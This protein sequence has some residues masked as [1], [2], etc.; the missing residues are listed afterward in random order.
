MDFTLSAYKEYIDLILKGELTVYCFKNFFKQKPKPNQFV[1]IRHD[2]D[3]KPYRALKMAQLEN[4][5]GINST[6]YFRSKPHTLN[7]EII[8]KIFSL[9]HE[10]G[11]HYE[12]LSDTNGNMNLALI[13]FKNNLDKLRKF[14][15]IS[16]ISMHGRPFSQYDNRDIWKD[17]LNHQQLLKKFGILGEVYLDIDYTDIAYINDTGRNWSSNQSNI[18]DKIISQV[19]CDFLNKNEL[20]KALK[21]KKFKKIIFQ[22]HPERWNDNILSWTQQYLFDSAVNI[23]KKVI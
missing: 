9:G 5:M 3:R 23:I 4:Q 16:T 11:Y 8:E 12:S 1:M 20:K 10:I 21:E 7:K 14:A 18:R 13:D 6:Y 17:K 15:P 2:V 22:I 19:D